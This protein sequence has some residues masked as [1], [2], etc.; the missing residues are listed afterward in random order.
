MKIIN[1][2]GVIGRDIKPEDIQ[3]QL[4]GAKGQ[5][6]E[7]QINSPG[8]LVT[9]GIEIYNMLNNYKGNIITKVTG[10]AASMGSIIALAGKN[11]PIV[12]K[13]SMF[14]I[15]NVQGIAMGD[16]NELKKE[17]EVME[18]ISN[19]MGRLYAKKSGKKFED[20]NN[21]CKCSKHLHSYKKTSLH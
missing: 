20:I 1:I 3:K 19:M 8:G 2:R 15:H 16:H 17:A 10:L 4:N 11:K 6:I 21:L 14:M 7:L 5:D 13:N 18:R 12:Y 9:Q